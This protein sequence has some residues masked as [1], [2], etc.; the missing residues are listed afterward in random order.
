MASSGIQIV[1]VALTV[2]GLVGAIITCILPQ[3]KV[4]A[5]I[6]D[7]IV[8]AQSTY[9]GIWKSCVVQ[10]T[11]Q[12]QCKDYDSLLVLSSDLQA[13]RA[14]T[15]V[16]CLLSGLAL[17]IIFA[18]SDFTTCVQN[19]DI[20]PKICLAGGIMLLVA[21][22]LIIIPVSWVA[23]QVVQNFNNVLVA[24]AQKRELGA[25]IFIGW[26]SGVLMLLAGGLLCCFSRGSRGSSTTVKYSTHPS[27]PKNY[28]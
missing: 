7:N 18:G 12:Q 16:C 2:L 13:S 26:G 3:W 11:G 27:A 21:G 14:M 23:N 10:S 8:T 15:I 17:L 5:F 28:V 24:Q 25:C 4:S 1:C 19:E 22:L 6:G 9:E 20:K